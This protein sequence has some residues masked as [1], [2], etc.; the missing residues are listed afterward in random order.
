MSTPGRL[1]YSGAAFLEAQAKNQ[2][3]AIKENF[4]EYL[5]TTPQFQLSP[6]APSSTPEDFA[7]RGAAIRTG[8]EMYGTSVGEVKVLTRQEAEGMMRTIKEGS[9]NEVGQLMGRLMGLGDGV[10]QAAFKQ[11]GE[12]DGVFEHA[13]RLYAGGNPDTGLDVIRGRKAVN[14]DKNLKDAVG[15]RDRDLDDAMTKELGRSL[16][17][18]PDRER[19]LVRE[20]AVAHFAQ[21][22]IKEGGGALKGVFDN[23]ARE[24]FRNSL[25]AVLG[26]NAASKALG[27]VNGHQ[28]LL[29]KGVTPREMDDAV[30]SLGPQDLVRLSVTGEPPRF[31]DGGIADPDAIST[32]GRFEAVGQNKYRIRMADGGLLLSSSAGQLGQPYLIDLS[33]D[34]VRELAKRKPPASVGLPVAP[35]PAEGALPEPLQVRPINP[36]DGPGGVLPLRIPGMVE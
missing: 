27:P 8:A 36:E 26:G 13:A 11:L 32:E 7:A 34:N 1:A 30:D 17:G 4:A 24:A 29:P 23:A 14:E 3:K 20:A 25:N 10:A 31:R 35:P 2:Q 19:A 5:N 21:T 22:Y 28:T 6:I 12:T 15:L 9:A 18:L 33:P 16:F